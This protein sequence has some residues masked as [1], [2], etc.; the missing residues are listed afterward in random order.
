[1]FITCCFYHQVLSTSH[2]KKTFSQ[3]HSPNELPRNTLSSSHHPLS[4]R[5]LYIV[6]TLFLQIRSSSIDNKNNRLFLLSTSSAPLN[7]DTFYPSL[8]K[9]TSISFLA[10]PFPSGYPASCDIFPSPLTRPDRHLPLLSRLLDAAPE[11]D[12]PR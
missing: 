4:Q 6:S 8:I 12:P 9:R 1:M 3:Q 5:I 10:R 7:P 11:I 2:T